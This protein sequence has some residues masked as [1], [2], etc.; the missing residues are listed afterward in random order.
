MRGNLI[1]FS[2]DER[3]AELNLSWTRPSKVG[4]VQRVG[5]FIR[6]PV[7]FTP[8]SKDPFATISVHLLLFLLFS[9]LEWMIP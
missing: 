8:V 2:S 5:L 6:V 7:S 1:G 3:K 4:E 9:V